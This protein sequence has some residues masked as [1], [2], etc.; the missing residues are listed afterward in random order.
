MTRDLP[1][2]TIE[3]MAAALTQLDI[4]RPTEVFDY[5]RE[6]CRVVLRA[7]LAEGGVALSTKKGDVR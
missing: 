1:D 3:A 2:G 4:F 5:H 6:I 7:A